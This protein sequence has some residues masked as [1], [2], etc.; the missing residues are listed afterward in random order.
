MGSGNFFALKGNWKQ[1]CTIVAA[2]L[3]IKQHVKKIHP[4]GNAK[5]LVNAG[6]CHKSNFERK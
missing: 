4:A 2:A 3:I 6:A 5:L 1:I